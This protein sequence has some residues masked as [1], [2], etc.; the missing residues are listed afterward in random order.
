MATVIFNHYSL[1]LFNF[2][3]VLGNVPTRHFYFPC[4]IKTTLLHL[5]PTS[6]KVRSRMQSTVLL[7]MDHSLVQ[8][9]MCAFGT[10]HKLINHAAILDTHTNFPL[11]MSITVNKQR[12]F[13]LVSTN[14]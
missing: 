6:S 9:M 14:S 5:L 1:I 3:V 10:I 2:K 13:L 12:T 8:V 11:V 7:V 4:A